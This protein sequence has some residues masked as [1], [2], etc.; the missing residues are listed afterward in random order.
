[1]KTTS[2]P[3]PRPVKS[4]S[5]FI[6][7][8]SAVLCGAL[9]A[10][11][12]YDSGLDNPDPTSQGWIA[13]EIVAGADADPADGMIDAG[14]NVGPVML[15][16]NRV[17]QINDLLTIDTGDQPGYSLPISNANETLSGYYMKGWEFRFTFCVAGQGPGA[18]CTGYAGLMIRAVDA[19]AA[20][21][22]PPGNVA[23]VGFLFGSQS[24][25]NLFV[26]SGPTVAT[27]FVD[28]VPPALH[29]ITVLGEAGSDR[30]EW[31]LD[32]IAQ[33]SGRIS[34]QIESVQADTSVIVFRAGS[35]DATDGATDWTSVALKQARPATVVIDSGNLTISDGGSVSEN[36]FRGVPFTATVYN[37]LARFLFAGDLHFTSDDLVRGKGSAAIS[38]TVSGDVTIDEGAVFDVS[39]R[40]GVPGPGGGDGASPPQGAVNA[41]GIGRAGGGS[42]EGGNGGSA[43]T[44]SFFSGTAGG[45]G[46]NGSYGN[47]GS[48]GDAGST[49]YGS[50]PGSAGFNAANSG[51]VPS[52]SQD[53]KGLGGLRGW[54][55]TYIGLGGAGSGVSQ[56]FSRNPGSP[57]T[58][59]GA[60]GYYGNAGYPGTAGSD[61]LGG[62]ANRSG[63][64]LTGGG[65]GSSGQAGGSGGGGGGG[66]SG[67]GGGGGGGSGAYAFGAGETGGKGGAGGAGGR[68]GNGGAGGDGGTGGFGGGAIEIIAYGHLKAAGRFDALGSAGQSGY[69]GAPAD[70]SARADGSPGGSGLTNGTGGRGGNGSKGGN[71]GAGGDGGPGGRGGGGAGGTIRLMGASVD[72][73]GMVADVSGGG[74]GAPGAT[75]RVAILSDTGSFKGAIIADAATALENYA[76]LRGINPH[77]SDFASTPLI[78]DLVGGAEVA[79]LLNGI[80]LG[81]FLGVLTAAPAEAHAAVMRLDVG[82]VGYDADFEGFDILLYFNLNGAPL[83]NPVLG[84]GAAGYVSRLLDGGVADL[85]AF[86]GSGPGILGELEPY[87]IY[88]TLIPEGCDFLNFGFSP[89]GT[90]ILKTMSM[91]TAGATAYLNYSLPRISGTIPAPTVH[92]DPLIK[93]PQAGPVVNFGFEG[94][95]QVT[96]EPAE[97]AAAGIGWYLQGR[98]PVYPSGTLAE[99]L[100]AG[101]HRLSFTRLP[102]WL[103][104]RD[105]S[106]T[107]SPDST[108]TVVATYQQAPTMQVGSIAPQRIRMGDVLGFYLGSIGGSIEVV[109]GNPNGTVLLSP[110]GWFSYEPAE[111]DR[112]PFEVRFTS[113]SSSQTVRITPLQDLPDEQTILALQPVSDPPSPAGRDFTFIHEKPAGTGVN[114]RAAEDCREITVSGVSLVFE[115]EGDNQLYAKVHDRKNITSLNLY[116]DEVIIRSPLKLQGTDVKIYARTLRFE[117]PDTGTAAID[118]SAVNQTATDSD[119]AQDGGD[120]TLHVQQVISDPSASARLV[121][122]GADTAENVT[123]GNSGQLSSPF[124][125]TDF[126]EI[127]GGMNT[128]T[129]G[130]MGNALPAVIHPAGAVPAGLAW[131]HP[132]AVRSLILYAKDIYY[133]GFMN[134]AGEILREYEGFLGQLIRIE[135][136]PPLPHAELAALQFSEQLNDITSVRD[137]IDD[138]L[139]YYGNPAGWVPLLSFEANFRLT[140]KA[141]GRTMRTLYLSHW[142]TSASNTI[143]N[144][145][146]AMSAARNAL[147]DDT[148]ALKEEF[149]S[150][151]DE[152]RLLDEKSEEID[153]MTIVVGEEL[154]EI[155]RR[156]LQKAEEIVEERNKVPMWKTVLRTAAKILE[157]VPFYQPALGAAGGLLEIGSRIDEQDPLDT[158]LQTANLALE[159]KAASYNKQA[160]DIDK[161]LNPPLPKSDKE[162][163]RDELLAKANTINTAASGLSQAGNSL[164][165]YLASREAPADEVEAELEKIRATDPQFNGVVARLRNL[166]DEK[167]RYSRRI[168]AL[169]NRLREIPGIILKNRIA[170]ISIGDAIDANNTVLDPQALSVVKEAE[171]RG[172]DRLRRY[173][174]LLAKSFEYRLLKPYREEGVQVYDPVKVFEKIEQI[175]IAAGTGGNADTEVG[176]PH[177]LSAAG[178]Q[179]LSAV[180]EEELALLS[181]RIVAAFEEGEVEQTFPYT[182]FLLESDL[183]GLN[184]TGG[185][186]VLNLHRQGVY[187]AGE[188]A[189]RISGLAVTGVSYVLTI[190]GE[191]VAADDPRLDN[192]ATASVDLVFVHSGISKLSRK[193]QTYSFNH[194]RNGDPAKNPIRWTA[195]ANLLTGGVTMVVPSVAAESLLQTLLGGDGDLNML[196]FSRPAANADIAV[197][198]ENLN[199][200]FVGGLPAG[201]I[202][203]K[204]TRISLQTQLDYFNSSASKLVDVRIIDPSG[205]PLTIQPRILFDR[206]GGGSLTDAFGRRDALG[207]VSRSFEGVDTLRITAE[208]FYG[209][210]FAESSQFPSGYRFR[211]WLDQSFHQIGTSPAVTISNSGQRRIYA[212]YEP[213]GDLNAPDVESIEL[214]SQDEQVG[215]VTYLV[216]FSENVYGVGTE[217]FRIEGQLPGYGV[218]AVEG[219]GR[220]RTVR[221]LT[222]GLPYGEF[223]FSLVDDDSILDRTGNSLSGDGKG[224]GD[225]VATALIIVEKGIVLQVIGVVAGEFT[226]GLTGAP[227]TTY[228]I[229]TADNLAGP[230]EVLKNV[231][232]GESGSVIVVD[233]RELAVRRFYRARSEP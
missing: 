186:S 190:G 32:G 189:H 36:T 179:S 83:R 45:R 123:A 101:E 51:A 19:P 33:G 222:G 183:E 162:I 221:I 77:L 185:H 169:E 31:Y 59:A 16:G 73:S 147:S 2:H 125:L 7:L 98:T 104:P 55:S 68:G 143:G 131:L 150:V 193:G 9:L 107:I 141:I 156:L 38:L 176:Q 108:M 106:V 116:A 122:R 100:P 210:E 48:S 229:E 102:G 41:P 171:A 8:V 180:F 216:R 217:D 166:M 105:R 130:G 211:Q 12:A 86:G 4:W 30:F 224:N 135:G 145:T 129:G 47:Q 153:E 142:L 144:R 90:L 70:N 40:A 78:P 11:F 192:L 191:P 203:V 197:R 199:L 81:S 13:S 187:P 158:I 49:G 178:F 109:S 42:V 136:L 23:R 80:N 25:G 161:E 139:D 88:A 208:Q 151:Q 93:L 159:Y 24:P 205:T 120:I 167:E 126:A 82:P 17:W 124:D 27:H 140:E 64:M 215:L 26:T 128:G 66:G 50:R 232:T 1:M 21:N 168:A 6:L 121:L 230:W 133:H 65:G 165:E 63:Q 92:P 14:A 201:G 29:T 134:Q 67:A 164:K 52:I 196:N 195:K 127:Q 160:T 79:G 188:E 54:G 44:Y 57:G 15:N 220:T 115:P 184:Q 223:G 207:A 177:L 213:L 146:A 149:P 94:S 18:S 53:N 113:G 209:S 117:D 228:L 35:S 10:D 214:V 72:T 103:P 28:S 119:P 227:A 37:G 154:K 200:S 194:F 85:S 5:A 71:G 60:E 170:M 231:T 172:K 175:L 233:T 163:E 76:G 132:M 84:V 22:I 182:T 91:P 3:I 181:D 198:A 148:D 34:D 62:G 74:G 157:V 61:G 206:V 87:G 58:Y 39:A 155:E 46:Q 89:E 75:G 218:S 43:G 112:A 95:L 137:R 202:G 174:Y 152:T 99:G 20:W 212:V 226:F 204:F 219:T 118:T 111:N 69:P 114:Y 138:R 56:G 97:A 225:V 173:F 110:D 96:I